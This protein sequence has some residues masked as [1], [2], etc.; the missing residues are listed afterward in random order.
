MYNRD[1]KHDFRD[2]SE[3][4]LYTAKLQWPK[5]LLMDQGRAKSLVN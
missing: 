2:R 1:K 3:I 4:A 5:P